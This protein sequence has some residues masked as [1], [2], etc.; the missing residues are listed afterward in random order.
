MHG[1]TAICILLGVFFDS[2]VIPAVRGLELYAEEDEQKPQSKNGT[3]KNYISEGKEMEPM[4][5]A[6]RLPQ[7][8]NNFNEDALLKTLED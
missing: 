2:F 4:M 5:T 1:L 8:T 6:V 3:N 7:P